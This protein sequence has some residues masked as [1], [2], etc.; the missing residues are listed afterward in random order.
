[1]TADTDS[2]DVL[3][4]G[5]EYTM[6]VS[7]QTN[8]P[9]ISLTPEE[10]ATAVEFELINNLQKITRV[11]IRAEFELTD[12]TT[13][14]N[15]VVFTDGDFNDI[16][17][18]PVELS[19]SNPFTEVTVELYPEF[20]PSTASWKDRIDS[21]LNRFTTPIQA[22][23]DRNPLF[24]VPRARGQTDGTNPPIFCFPSTQCGMIFSTIL[25]LSSTH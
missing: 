5:N 24:G 18:L 7:D 14:R 21:I 11:E 17:L 19:A 9:S 12:G 1:V 6:G 20:K 25:V 8:R 15:S 3:R 16:Q 23:T 2:A 22:Q 4:I 13:E 10:P